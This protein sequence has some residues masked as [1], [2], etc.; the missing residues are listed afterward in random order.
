MHF[1]CHSCEMMDITLEMDP[2]LQN[3]VTLSALPEN[4]PPYDLSL[5]VA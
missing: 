2:M 5:T 1:W 4:L 3:I